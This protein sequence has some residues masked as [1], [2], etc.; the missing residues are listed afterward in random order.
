LKKQKSEW[1]E[2]REFLINKLAT[3]YQN[4]E[5]DSSEQVKKATQV[6]LFVQ[7]NFLNFPEKS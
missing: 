4:L 6:E 5:G 2:E 1:M 3:A 7:F